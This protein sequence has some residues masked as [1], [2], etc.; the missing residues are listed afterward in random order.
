MLAI[1]LVEFFE[2]LQLRLDQISV[3]ARLDHG[4]ADC[5]PQMCSEGLELIVKFPASF[6]EYF[7][8]KLRRIDTRE[9]IVTI[10]AIV[11]GDTHRPMTEEDA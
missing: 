8:G 1:A 6:E 5:I 2:I 9:R 11:D 7:S 10:G 3:M 4:L